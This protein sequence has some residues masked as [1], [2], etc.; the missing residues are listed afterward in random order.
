VL[1]AKHNTNTNADFRQS[2][3]FPAIKADVNKLKDYRNNY[4]FM[5]HD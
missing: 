4:V 3:Y 1:D 2:H 5:W